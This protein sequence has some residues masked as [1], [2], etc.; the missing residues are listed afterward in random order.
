M[1]QQSSFKRCG[2]FPLDGRSRGVLGRNRPS[3]CIVILNLS[4][5]S[6]DI[7]LVFIFAQ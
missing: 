5:T 6:L 2:G 1:S 4:A 7:I 3:P